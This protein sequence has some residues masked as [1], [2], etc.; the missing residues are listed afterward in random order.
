MN[1]KKKITLPKNFR[2]LIEAG[3]L[4]ALKAVYDTCEVHATADSYKETALHYHKV[5]DELVLWLVSRG[6]DVNIKDR[7]GNTPLHKQ[8]RWSSGNVQLF[9]ELGADIN[10]HDNDN[11]TPLHSAAENG[12]ADAVKLLIAKGADIFAEGSGLYHP[13]T[14]LAYALEQCNNVKIAHIAE[15][16]EILLDAGTP[17]TPGMKES[18]KRIGKDFEFHRGNFNKDLLGETEA[19]LNKLYTLFNVEPVAKLQRH[20][21]VSPITV[22]A[23]GWQKQHHELWDFLVPS[24]G[25]AKTVQGEVIRIT[26]RVSD[27][28][29][30]NGGANWDV[31][32]RKMLNALLK[33]FASGATLPA[34]ELIEAKE[35]ASS[36]KARGDDEDEVIDRLC[37]LAVKWV[38]QNPNPVLLKKPDYNR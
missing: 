10:A 37:E 27:E 5:P 35:L 7:Y 34:K 8:V 6:L 13:V 32:Y 25:A 20:D 9:L 23:Q 16:A 19:G 15:V 4:D 2:E 12:N 14:S 29:Y 17:V 21:G 36:I 24:Q 3:D 1:A 11:K 31:N 30:R 18:V 22:T 38:L 28:L 26:G 33:H